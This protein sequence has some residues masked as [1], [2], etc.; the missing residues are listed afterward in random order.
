MILVFCNVGRSRHNLDGINM[1]AKVLSKIRSSA[2]R[3]SRC[4][5]PAIL[6]ADLPSLFPGLDRIVIIRIVISYQ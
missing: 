6:A 4:K 3:G 1:I 5:F 2:M